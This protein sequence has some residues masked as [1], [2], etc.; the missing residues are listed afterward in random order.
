MQDMGGLV[1]V[2]TP[3]VPWLGTALIVSVL[4]GRAAWW[5]CK[6]V[7]HTGAFVRRRLTPVDRPLPEQV[8]SLIRAVGRADRA[9]TDC[10]RHG[11]TFV[12]MKD[13]AFA[14]WAGEK[15]TFRK[16]TG[17]YE[18]RELRAVQKAA[19]ERLAFLAGVERDYL[20][21]AAAEGRAA[22]PAAPVAPAGAPPA[23]H[24]NSRARA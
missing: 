19:Q 18:D 13:G 8:L 24:G 4:L 23:L 3:Y 11:D 2:L 1:S 10:L 21:S 14:V 17:N 7:W 16:L 15:D 6:G 12:G 9:G 22:R 20:R 5:G